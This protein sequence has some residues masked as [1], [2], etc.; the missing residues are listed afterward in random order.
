MIPIGFKLDHIEGHSKIVLA[1]HGFTHTKV[2]RRA[3]LLLSLEAGLR[4]DF[5]PSIEVFLQ[6]KQD[7]SKLRKRLRGVELG[8]GDRRLE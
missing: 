4:K 5:S 7:A 2:S 3:G 1:L 6:P 8:A